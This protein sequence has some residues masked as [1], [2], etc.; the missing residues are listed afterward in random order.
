MVRF[1]APVD[2]VAAGSLF[3]VL[4]VI[5]VAS[6]IFGNI[7]ALLQNNVKRILAYSSIAHIGYLLV[8]FLVGGSLGPAAVTFYL[9]AYFVMTLGAFGVITVLSG[10]QREAE[11]IDD[12]RGLFWRRP[13]LGGAFTAMLLSLAGIPLT[14]GFIGKFYLVVAGVSASFWLLVIVLVLTSGIGLFYYLRVV[15]SIFR[16]PSSQP[17]V[18]ATQPVVAT[19]GTVVLAVLTIL[20]VGLGVAPAPLIR[21]IGMMVG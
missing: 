12:Y 3:A 17:V 4:T 2:I 13:W 11:H 16:Q 8:A 18:S 19:S 20:L 14:V 10:P 21:L 9:I 15:V 1:F 6:M 7:L 5:V